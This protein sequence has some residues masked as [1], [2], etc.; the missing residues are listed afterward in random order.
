[1]SHLAPQILELLNSSNEERI[2]ELR[3]KKWIGYTAANKA[4]AKMEDLLN[5]PKT[6]RMPNLLIKSD[7]NNGK[8]FLLKRFIKSHPS[9]EDSAN[10]KLIIP[11]VSIEIPAEPSPDVIYSL[12][13]QAMHIPYRES[14]K[15]EVKARKVFDAFE[16]FAVRILIIDELH[17]LMNTTKLKKAQLL[18]TL[19]YIGNTTEIVIV[20]AGTMEAHTAIVSDGQLANRFEPYVL[21][22]WKLNTDYRKLLATFEKIIPLKHASDLQSQILATEI[23]SMSSGW[24]GEINE[25]LTRAAIEAI[26]SGEEKITLETL[27]RIDW[28]TP[29]KR[30][31]TGISG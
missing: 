11:V 5:H 4:L 30:R 16:R 29:E 17:V 28:L 24:I 7:T 2:A 9:Y 31:F 8:S 19:K 23:Y 14:Y 3:R 6:H 12:I 18:D 15:K 26:H 22:Q 27:K 20:G 13:L 25:I 21:P 1:M 10:E